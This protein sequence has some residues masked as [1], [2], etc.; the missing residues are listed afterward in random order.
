MKNLSAFFNP[1]SVAVIGASTHTEKIGH[2]ILKNFVESSAYDGKIFPI[3]PNTQPVLGL[4]TYASVKD[5]PQ[6]IDLAVIAIPGKFVPKVLG[7]CGQAKVKAVTIISSG[8]KEIGGEGIKLEQQ[9]HKI[10]KKYNLTV[11]G[12][13][14]LG[15]LDTDSGVDMLF[16]PPYRLGRPKKGPIAFISQSG[17]FGSAILDWSAQEGFGVSK[18]ISYG[19]AVD[20]DEV[21]LLEYL[22]KDSSTKV[23]SVYLEGANRAR[24]FMEVAKKVTKK[25]PVLIY[26]AGSSKMGTKAAQSHTGSLA[27][28]HIIYSAAFKQSG[29]MQVDNVEDMFDFA[30]ALSYQPLPK[31]NRIAIVTDGGGF[32]VL[33]SDHAE[34]EGLEVVTPSP[35]TIKLMKKGTLPYASLHNPIDLTGSADGEMYKLAIEAC[36][37]DPKIDGVVVILLFQPPNIDSDVI[38]H[39][40]DIHANYNKPLL[41][42]STGGTYTQLHRD[43][44]DQ[45]GVPTFNTPSAA[46]KSM[47]ALY[48][49]SQIK[50]SKLK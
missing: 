42:T 30:R 15:V 46:V 48:K 12:P 14:C 17:A 50:K 45:S 32:G 36:M 41:V 19:N 22:G 28:A 37:Q 27:G 6:R 33:A 13:N 49:Y 26:K 24:E 31:G 29:I 16:L 5:V 1:K 8:F 11:I 9:L 43:I 47:A 23:V 2:V 3:N 21:D 44:L 4:K 35:Q 38:Q 20:V 18:F 39:I 10:I 25:K 7:E 40:L 34:K